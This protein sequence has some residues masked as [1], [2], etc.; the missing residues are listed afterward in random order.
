M[1]AQ[2]LAKF[3]ARLDARLQDDEA[4]DGLAGDLV[5]LADDRGFGDPLVVDQGALDLGRARG[6]GR[7]RS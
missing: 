7:R 6:G 4:A 5:R 2:L 1:L 3:V